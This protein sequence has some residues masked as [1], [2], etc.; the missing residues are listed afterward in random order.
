MYA[1]IYLDRNEDQEKLTKIFG[2]LKNHRIAGKKYPATD[3]TQAYKLA[4][5]SVESNCKTIIAIGNEEIISAVIN[6][7]G[8]INDKQSFGYIPFDTIG[9]T[10]DFIGVND[11]NDALETILARKIEQFHLIS[12][13]KGYFLNQLYVT[14]N[15]SKSTLSLTADRSFNAKASADKIILTNLLN[16]EGTSTCPV[17]LE[18]LRLPIQIKTK[19]SFW[20]FKPM[21]KIKKQHERILFFKANL[22]KIE[23]GDCNLSTNNSLISSSNLLI[24]RNNREINLIVKKHR[25]ARY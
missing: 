14:I 16:Q 22:I 19:K 1:Y 10:A 21:L 25:M 3:I 24:G 11:T 6:A 15:Q 9:E 8:S 23:P 7:C 2:W 13:N 20:N 17:S 5:A 12:V 18:A 4:K